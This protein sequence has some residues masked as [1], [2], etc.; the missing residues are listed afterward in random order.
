MR[1]IRRNTARFGAIVALIVA[2]TLAARL[3]RQRATSRELSAYRLRTQ[4]EILQQ[5]QSAQRRQGRIYPFE[6]RRHA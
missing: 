4:G 1:D 6:R 5:L 2:A 3:V